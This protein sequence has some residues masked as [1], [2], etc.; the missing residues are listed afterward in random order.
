MTGPT[1]RFRANFVE[2]ILILLLVLVAHET[3]DDARQSRSNA[4]AHNSRWPESVSVVRRALLIKRFGERLKLKRDRSNSR[5]QELTR[6]FVL[7]QTR[8]AQT[9]SGRRN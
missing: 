7:L 1:L 6:I 5:L 8:Y 3:Y 4:P 2:V 9:A